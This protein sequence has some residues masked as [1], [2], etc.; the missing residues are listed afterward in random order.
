MAGIN[1]IKCAVCGFEFEPDYDSPVCEKCPVFEL[2]KGCNFAKCP[3]CGYD[4]IMMKDYENLFLKLWN[5]I[6]KILKK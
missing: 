2:K 4:N 6:K 3:N 5:K 1:K